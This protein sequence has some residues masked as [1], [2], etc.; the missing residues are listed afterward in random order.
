LAFNFSHT[1]AG[2]LVN[3]MEVRRIFRAGIRPRW[4]V[5]EVLPSMLGISN[6]ST[7]AN[8]ARADDLIFLS[9][10]M[11][12]YQSCGTYALSRLR[13][14]SH[15]YVVALDAALPTWIA[16][17]P[18]DP[19]LDLGP[20][21]GSSPLHADP[22]PDNVRRYT[23]A[24]QAQYFP[25]LQRL[26]VT[27]VADQSL[28]ELLE[29]C[30]DENVQVVLLLTPESSEFRGWYPERTRQLVESYCA[31]LGQEYGV[32]VVDARAWLADADFLDAH[33]ALPRGAEVFTR[34]LADEVLQPLVTGKLA[35]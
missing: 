26:R 27:G 14:S 4:L 20:L 1:G 2:P 11:P 33:H 21:G 3:L 32:R 23:Q 25:G 10:H 28:R 18:E 24:V 15:N 22:S 17:P 8:L 34:R 19:A 12:L 5:V 29:L 13:P 7:A 30:L 16:R 35:P 9:R 31:G 6:R